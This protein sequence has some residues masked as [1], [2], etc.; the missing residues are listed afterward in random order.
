MPNKSVTVIDYGVGN[1]LSIC[2]AFKSLGG[3]VNVTSDPQEI[4]SSDRILLPGVGAFGLAMDKLLTLNLVEPLRT[5]GESGKPFLGIC[6]GM[7]LLM[8]NSEE[9]GFNKG[10]GLI[11]GKNIK[12]PDQT[13]NGDL[14]KRPQIGWNQI[15]PNT[16]KSKWEG[17]LLE[18]HKAHESLYFVH[19]YMAIPQNL[20]DRLAFCSYGGHEV[21]AAISSDNIIGFQFHPEKSGE[22]GL[23]ILN[24]FLSL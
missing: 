19:S 18:D 23:K 17:T 10:L 3:E 4:L 1:I 24:H 12:I 20:K 6:L 9:F 7:Q 11:S 16:D 5:F 2:R 21:T 8:N 15:H 14:L 13:V 22:V